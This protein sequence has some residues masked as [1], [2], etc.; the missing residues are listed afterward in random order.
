MDH[1]PDKIMKIKILLGL[2]ILCCMDVFSQNVNIKCSNIEEKNDSVTVTLILKLDKI[3]SNDKLTI[4]PILYNGNNNLIINRIVMT[5]RNRD[6]SDQRRGITPK[7]SITAKEKDYLEYRSTVALT[8]VGAKIELIVKDKRTGMTGGNISII[9]KEVVLLFAGKE[10]KFFETADNQ[11]L[12]SNF[13]SADA[14]YP[15]PNPSTP[16]TALSD[17]IT[18]PF[19]INNEGNI[20]NHFYT[21][22][23]N[24]ATMPTILAIKSTKTVDGVDGTVYYPIHFSIADA[25]YTITPGN[26]YRVIITLNGDVSSG[27]GG[28][29]V[30]P[31][32][33]VI[34]AEIIVTVQEAEWIAKLVSKEFQ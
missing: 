7:I 26:K 33:P 25:G 2:G 8:F 17:A 24:G 9:D 13:Y 21:F 10:G 34:N 20:F 18:A 22:G 5:G 31:E 12:Q 19:S 27:G 3:M 32:Q 29:T 6:I 28:G 30:D 15:D 4:T 11:V 23:N 14:S 16:S 1:K